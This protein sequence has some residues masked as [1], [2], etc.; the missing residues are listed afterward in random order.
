MAGEQVGDLYA[1][2][3][4]RQNGKGF[5]KGMA[6]LAKAE[7]AT[8]KLHNLWQDKQGRWRAAGGRY[9]TTA[10]KAAMG[11]KATGKEADKAKAKMGGFEKSVARA[12]LAVA[13]YFGARAIGKALIGFNSTVED[14]KIQIA[15]M[16]ALASGTTVKS[17]LEETDK[18]YAN[19]QERA[20]SLPGTTKDYA[21]MLS[22]IAQP[23]V[24][25]GAGLKQLE[26]LTVNATV[27]AKAFG[28]PLDVAA[29]DIDAAMM[30]QFHSVD[31]LN[32][33]ILEPLGYKGEE[34]RKK[35][36][37]LSKEKRLSEFN[38][39]LMTP[40]ITELAEMQGKTFSGRMSTLTD[41]VERL[42]GRIGKALFDRLGKSMERL[43][44]W[45]DKNKE[46]VEKFA[47]SMGGA[48]AEAFETLGG[49]F[50][51]LMEHG[52][53]VQA[54]MIGFGVLLSAWALKAAAAWVIALGPL[55]LAAAAI[56]LLV[57]QF[58]RIGGFDGFIAGL[59]DLGEDIKNFFI[60]IKDWIVAAFD[61]AI[62]TVKQALKD[63]FHSMM[64]NP[65]VRF[66]IK[67]VGGVGEL[68][69]DQYDT[70]MR[71]QDGVT[72]PLE[73]MR[74]DMD[75]GMGMGDAMGN[76][77]RNAGVGGGGGTTVGQVQNN[78]N[79]QGPDAKQVVAE[80]ERVFDQK[81]GA[82]LSQT[83]DAVG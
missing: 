76:F 41:F 17:R 47:D 65:V 10:E 74:S 26:D 79:I 56:G 72:D 22:M 25:A 27:A 19:L 5:A 52:E 63:M 38:R 45:L 3:S 53:E 11:I 54:F 78:F 28:I 9:A 14:T 83:Q 37:A 20:A 71:A 23:I 66:A 33:K 73:Q 62:A 39:G 42:F 58:R 61:T 59:K 49:I 67:T 80:A 75:S 68:A 57:Y 15:G 4:L 70:E 35:Y 60:G 13:A 34:G 24:D 40:Q 69:L 8:N 48:L 64:N 50:G 18:L 30:G 36:N 81:M 32:R 29:R 82:L 51:W 31:K 46:K 7:A 1:T 21:E 16:I 55:G 44:V 2:L 43:A 77:W 12:G 6:Q